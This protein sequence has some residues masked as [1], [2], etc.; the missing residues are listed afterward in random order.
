VN[1]PPIVIVK[2]IAGRA[3]R[4]TLIPPSPQSKAFWSNDGVPKES[5]QQNL[6]NPTPSTHNLSPPSTLDSSSCVAFSPDS[7]SLVTGGADGF[8]RLFRVRDIL[9]YPTERI[10]AS[11]NAFSQREVGDWINGASFFP[12]GDHVA[13]TT[14]RQYLVVSVP[15]LQPVGQFG[16]T[17]LQ[18]KVA[19]AFNS[20]ISFGLGEDAVAEADWYT[21]REICVGGDMR[22]V[23][24]YDVNRTVTLAEPLCESRS[25]PGISQE[26]LPNFSC[27]RNGMPVGGTHFTRGNTRFPMHRREGTVAESK[28]LST[29]TGLKPGR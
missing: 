8:L 25:D 2:I 18:G 20:K 13:L 19:K 10:D 15:K 12:S 16:E 9:A 14:T 11:E 1:A 29:S 23:A 6:L 26:C 27:S 17:G 24:K 28:E 3:S 21:G 5:C 4:H 7:K 22:R